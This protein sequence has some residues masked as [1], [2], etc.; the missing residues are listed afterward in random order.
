MAL[1]EKLGE[2][3]GKITSTR[4]VTP[5]G[6]PVQ[7]EITFQGS[8]QMIGAAITDIGTYTQTVR[9]GGILYGEGNALFITNAGE[10]AHWRGFGVGRPT[11]PFP[12]GHMA[13]CGSTQTE[14]QGLI[15]LNEIATVVEY[16]VEHNG[17][18]HWTAWE[19]K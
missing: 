19:W 2:S 9:P 11:G 3:S 17:D 12:A 8:G 18:Y 1:G 14:S 15:L 7:I 16:D 13:V 4:V 10:S 6:E 5:V